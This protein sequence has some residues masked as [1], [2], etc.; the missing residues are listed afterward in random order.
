MHRDNI[1]SKIPASL[2]RELLEELVC[3]GGTRIERI[4]SKGHTTPEGTWYDQDTSEWVMVVQGSARLRFEE[5]D[6]LLS[7]QA[8]DWIT[9]PAHVKHRVEWTDPD[10]ET[11]W[12]AV[13]YP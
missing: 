10:R 13:H 1:A 6:V 9:I 8:G 11:I 2:P 5:D 12:L 3:T 4:I 7:M